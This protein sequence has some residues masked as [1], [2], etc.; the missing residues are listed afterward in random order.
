MY[1]MNIF[2]G[3]GIKE[4][5][6]IF[7][8]CFATLFKTVQAMHPLDCSSSTSAMMALTAKKNVSTVIRTEKMKA[9]RK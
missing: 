2:T 9:T 6:P 7:K 4:K 5:H 8:N 1:K 3:K